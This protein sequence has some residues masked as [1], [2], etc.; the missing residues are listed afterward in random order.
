MN[1]EC[2]LL[3]FLYFI[4]CVLPY[5]TH[6][7]PSALLLDELASLTIDVFSAKRLMIIKT[8]TF[9]RIKNFYPANIHLCLLKCPAPPPPI[10]H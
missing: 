8:M 1:F 9:L 10:N 3:F 2:T 4:L 7:L 5:V 6:L